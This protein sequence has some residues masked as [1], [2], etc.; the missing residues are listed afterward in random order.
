M[1]RLTLCGVLLAAVAS[2]SAPNAY[3]QT[4]VDLLQPSARDVQ[5]SDGLGF[6]KVGEDYVIRFSDANNI[7]KTSRSEI[8]QATTTDSDGQ[9]KSAGPVAWNYTLSLTVFHVVRISGNSWVLLKH[10]D[11]PDDFIR[12]GRQRQAKAILAAA[13]PN[14]GVD[15]PNAQERLKRLREDAAQQIATTQTWINLSHAIAIA[16]VPIDESKPQLSI[17][18]IKVGHKE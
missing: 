17:T 11:N 14:D 4:S 10:P 6:L 5:P 16:P 13:K 8:T 15:D 18:S 12:W 2:P 3:S 1:K 7:F 9:T